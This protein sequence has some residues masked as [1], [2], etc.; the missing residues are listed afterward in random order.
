MC[1]EDE[2]LKICLEFWKLMTESIFERL[3][4][5]TDGFNSIRTYPDILAHL[6]VILMDRMVKPQEVLISIDADG[7]IIDDE[8]EDHEKVDLYETMKSV[9]IYVTNIDTK[10]MDSSLNDRLEQITKHPKENFPYEILSKLCWCLGSIS[11]CMNEPEE[12][13]FIVSVIKE[14]LNLTERTQGKSNKA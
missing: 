11:G 13:K 10:A 14:L 5:S 8:E 3:Q 9:I 2:L 1:D 6:R 12:S 4:M 7:E